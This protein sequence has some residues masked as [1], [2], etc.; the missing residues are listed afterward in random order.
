MGLIQQIEQISQQQALAYWQ[1]HARDIRDS[2]DSPALMDYDDFSIGASF[3]KAAAASI[4]YSVQT[5]CDLHP[6][7]S[8][9]RV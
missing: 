9:G 7:L 8:P 2:V 6:E 1:E 5:R 4:S 3:R